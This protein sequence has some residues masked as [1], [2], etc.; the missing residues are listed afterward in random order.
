MQVVIP[1]SSL[2]GHNACKAYLASP[3]WNEEKQALVYDDW[4]KTAARLFET[5][6]GMSY[7]NWLV[8]N[9]LVPMSTNEF[10]EAR[11]AKGFVL[12]GDT[13]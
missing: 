8:A 11:K 12:L 6:A 4:A 3:E 5:R 13:K 1:I 10:T 9:K 2:K 7:L